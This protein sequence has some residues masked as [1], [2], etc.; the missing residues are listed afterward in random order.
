MRLELASRPRA[1]RGVQGSLA[2]EHKLLDLLR[3]RLA[4]ARLILGRQLVSNYE[5]S[6]PN[7]VTVVLE[8]HGFTDLLNRLTYLHTAEQQQQLLI[9]ITRT[10]RAQADAAAA[11]LAKLEATDRQ[12]TNGAAL[13]A[14]ALAGMNAL[15]SSKQAALQDARAAQQ[16]AL[17]AA[18]AKGRAL[19]AAISKRPGAAG[20]RPGRTAGPRAGRP[21]PV[22][23]LGDPVRDRFVRIRRTEP[24]AQQR[25]GVRA[26]TRSSPAPGGCSAAPDRPR[27][28]RAR[29]NRTLSPRGSGTAAPARRTGSAPGSSGSTRSLRAP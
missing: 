16:A 27:T 10:A 29:L 14:R 17:S 15:L 7:I 20:G 22:R 23:R 28:S 13:R 18:R 9:K 1:S 26:T 11:R 6:K 4:R 24:P 25:R 2:R 5:S 8:A 12:I 21:R 3:A 19:Q